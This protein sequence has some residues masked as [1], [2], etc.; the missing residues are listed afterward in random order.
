M[1]PTGAGTG[2]RAGIPAAILNCRRIGSTPLGGMASVHVHVTD[3]SAIESAQPPNSRIV[4]DLKWQ[5]GR[6]GGEAQVDIQRGSVF[7][8]GAADTITATARIIPANDTQFF[9]P[10]THKRVEATVCWGGSIN[11]KNALGTSE[12]V[13]VSAGNVSARLPIP[14][15]AEALMVVTDDPAGYA[16]LE[17]TFWRSAAGGARAYAAF[18]PF[19]NTIPIVA[20]AEYVTFTTVATAIIYPIWVLHL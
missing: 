5:S 3:D 15:Q 14:P 1:G 9:P 19:A 12:G 11:P 17:A 7:T 20:G 4:M 18:N 13:S 16:T 6:G 8:V 10:P 2:D